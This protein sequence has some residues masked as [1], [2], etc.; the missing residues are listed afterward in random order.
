MEIS[1]KDT[2]R[3]LRRKKNVTQ[4]ALA[5]HLGITPQSVGKWERGEGYPDITLLPKIALY[6]GVTIDDLLNVGQARIDEAIDAY[7]EESKKMMNRGEAEKNIE[8]WERAYAEFPNDCRVM[9]K[10]MYA[11]SFLGI[12]PY[13]EGHVERVIELGERILN[14]SNDTSMREGAIQCLCYAYEDRG[15][16][17]NALKYAD[18]GGSIN[19]TSNSLRMFILKGE[20]GIEASQEYI[21][22]L[23]SDAAWAACNITTK[24]KLSH[25]ENILAY[26]FAIDIL[27]FLY[28]DGN[29][30]FGAHALEHFHS[31]LAWEYIKLGDAEKTLDA[32]K[33]RMKYAIISST[34]TDMKYTAPMVNRLTY[35]PGAATKNYKG[36]ECYV[37]LKELSYEKYDFIRDNERFKR[38]VEELKKYADEDA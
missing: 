36:N 32:L 8:L 17:E 14:E 16:I 27:K 23:I 13:P 24:A 37:Y 6:F 1:I 25:E 11:I 18:M 10:L 22:T 19:V 30:G 5:N 3:E 15:D 29:V 9:R 35:S 31:C 7:Y 4:E 33:E 20:E 28:S 38:I 34:A 21:K 12:R 26:Q 2:L